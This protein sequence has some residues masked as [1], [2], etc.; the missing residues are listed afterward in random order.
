ML[1]EFQKIGRLLFQEGLIDSHGG[2]L[3]LRQGDK[4]IITRRDAMLGELQE[5]D[6]VEVGIN[7]GEGDAQACRELASHRAIYQNTGAQAIVHA[8]GA[9]T[10]AL[11]ITDNKIVPQDAEGLHLY[12]SASIVRVRQ[13]IGSDEAARLLPSFLQGGNVIAAVKGFGSFAT[14]KSLEEAYRY[15]S[16]LENSCRVLVA[17]RS[18]SGSR[19]PQPRDREKV[20]LHQQHRRSAIPPGIGVMDRSR[21][22]KR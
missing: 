2:N 4:I 15:T 20:E 21:Y 7:P 1:A 12:K 16:C 10:I 14:G 13:A 18:S 19:P 6:L 8:H 5:G 3:S 9:N 11:S 22:N 17:V